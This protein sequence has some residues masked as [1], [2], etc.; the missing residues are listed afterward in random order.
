MT[1]T[2][3]QRDP[4]WHKYPE[5]VLHFAVEPPLAID[6]RRIPSAVDVRRLGEIGL[7]GEFSVITAHDPEGRDLSAYENRKRAA[8]LKRRLYAQGAAF[9]EV[10]AC[11][12]DGSHCECSVA[13]PTTRSGAVALA[14]AFDQVAVFWFDGARFW[15]LSALPTTEPLLLPQGQL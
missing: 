8:A 11:S 13:T 5:T 4:D 14:R 12:P 2:P 15:I 10:D 3:P 1:E 9:V 6:L 7:T